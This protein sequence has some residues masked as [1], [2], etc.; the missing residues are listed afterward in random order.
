MQDSVTKLVFGQ[1]YIALV[2]GEI[3]VID[4]LSKLYANQF[5]E[6]QGWVEIAKDGLPDLGEE[7]NVVQDIQDGHNKPVSTC[8]EFDGVK[9]VWCYPGTDL[10]MDSITHWQPIPSPPNKEG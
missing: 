8:S 1:P 2:E 3:K 9:K 4:K 5:R 6:E 7:Y 10:I